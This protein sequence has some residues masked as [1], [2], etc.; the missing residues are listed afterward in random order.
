MI[1]P[2]TTVSVQIAHYKKKQAYLLTYKKACATEVII[3]TLLSI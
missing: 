2:T 1:M 3:I